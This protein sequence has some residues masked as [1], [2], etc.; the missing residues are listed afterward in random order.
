VRI[1]LTAIY[2]YVFILLY[3]IT[4]FDEYV[5]ALPNILMGILIIAFPFV[6]TKKDFKKLLLKPTL[7][8][9]VLIIFFLANSFFQGRFEQDFVFIK[10]LMI[11]IGV[12]F[13][14][15][16]IR[17][18]KKLNK[19]IVFSSFLAIMFTLIQFLILVNQNSNV[20]IAFFQE[21]VDAILIDRVYVGLL[22]LLSIL[23][24][25]KFLTKNY[26]PDNKYYLAS[27]IINALYLLLIMS[28][29]AL[30]ILFIII[31]L[32]QFYGE[33]KKTRRIITGIVLVTL[34]LISFL[35]YQSIYKGF[36]QS[37]KDISEITYY[38]STLPLGYRTQ[39]WE[40]VSKIYNKDSNVLFGI[41]FKETNNRLVSCYENEIE[42]VKTKQNFISKRFNTHNQYLDFYISSG[43][44]SLV[45][46][47]GIILY[48]FFKNYKRFH[49]TAL[50]ITIILFGLVENFFHRQ[51]GA[52]YFGFILVILFI[53]NT[54]TDVSK[55][56]K[57]SSN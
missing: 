27:I 45:L 20:T 23:I 50:L 4:P 2:P 37:N 32:R 14:Y 51:I 12:V 16:P 21:T 48:L 55:T 22:C 9:A 18:F 25:Y 33:H 54:N 36:I 17:N 56:D 30:V 19:A 40:C 49:P 38:Q 31:V 6:I 7:L 34:I 11:P 44:I 1:L 26:H 28:K 35:K 46:F 53:N 13:L 10:K 8:L 39:V 15:L 57:K 5:R 29:T 47:L 52:Y 41:G 3:L 24:S 43:L 42:D